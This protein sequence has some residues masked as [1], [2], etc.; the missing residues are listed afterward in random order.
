MRRLLAGTIVCGLVA[1]MMAITPALAAG[2]SI[3]GLSHTH[4][5]GEN[6][7]YF[8]GKIKGTPGTRYIAKASGPAVVD[9]T[10]RFKMGSKGVRKVVFEIEAAGEYTLKVRKASR[11]RILDQDS[12]MVPPPPP[13]GDAEGPFPCVR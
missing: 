6:F 2:T 12:Y 4:P 3:R 10:V 11:Q 1:L 8:C 13:G 5:E 9:D 7:S